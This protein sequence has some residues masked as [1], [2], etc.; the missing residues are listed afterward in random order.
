M[1]KIKKLSVKVFENRQLQKGKIKTWEFYPIYLSVIFNKKVTTL[2]SP[3]YEYISQTNIWRD[4]KPEIKVFEINESRLFKNIRAF[5]EDNNIEFSTSLLKSEELVYRFLSTPLWKVFDFEFRMGI[6]VFLAKFEGKYAN[7]SV[8]LYE[9]SN[10]YS[11]V[12]SI[13]EINPGLYLEMVTFLPNYFNILDCLVELSKNDIFPYVA[14]FLQN[15]S[16]L[17][18]LKS[19]GFEYYLKDYQDLHFKGLEKKLF[20]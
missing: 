7:T 12:E 8:L 15:E 6:A 20:I 3:F 11:F 9:S 5:F 14:D 4:S 1:A 2:K 10:Y 18:S 16:F 13:K 19:K 17:D